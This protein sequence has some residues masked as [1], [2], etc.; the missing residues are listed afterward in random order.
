MSVAV[1]SMYFLFV[2]TLF[3]IGY[4][5][6]Y[7]LRAMKIEVSDE[8]I[9]ENIETDGLPQYDDPTIIDTEPYNEHPTHVKEFLEEKYNNK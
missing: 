9:E 3:A 8:D 2:I 6:W 1:I 4:I 5:F 7:I